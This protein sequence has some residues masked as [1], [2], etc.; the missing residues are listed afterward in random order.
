MGP[1]TMNCIHFVIDEREADFKNYNDFSSN[2]SGD[3]IAIILIDQICLV[4]ERYQM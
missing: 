3:Q 4:S 1:M 2:L